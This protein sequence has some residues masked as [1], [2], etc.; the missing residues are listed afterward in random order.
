MSEKSKAFAKVIFDDSL[1]HEKEEVEEYN[2]RIERII[3]ELEEAWFTVRVNNHAPETRHMKNPH[4]KISDRFLSI[5]R[6]FE[7]R[8]GDI[9]RDYAIKKTKYRRRVKEILCDSSITEKNVADMLGEIPI[10]ENKSRDGFL[11]ACIALKREIEDSQHNFH[12][13]QHEEAKRK[14]EKYNI[15]SKDDIYDLNKQLALMEF[16]ENDVLQVIKQ[17]KVL[18]LH[19]KISIIP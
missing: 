1:K 6:M 19:Q 5:E 15:N 3:K 12:G 10:H 16:D 2:S 4:E 11:E 8:I 14:L 17:I 7:G 9:L 18:P 13:M